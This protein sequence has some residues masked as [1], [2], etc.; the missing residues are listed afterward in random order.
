[1]DEKAEIDWVAIEVEYRAGIRTIQDI[2]DQYKVTK[3][4]I[5]N[6]AK[7]N[8]W[9]RDLSGK[10]K[11]KADELVNKAR[12]NNS[13]NKDKLFTEKV[14]VQT[15]AELQAGAILQESDE[16][17]RLSGIAEAMEVELEG[18]PQ[19]ADGN[20]LDLEKRSRILKQLT[21]VREKIIN[22]R[23]R[24]LGINDNANGTADQAQQVTEIRRVV[25]YPASH[26]DT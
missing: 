25:V 11:A 22:L 7:R 23:R 18:M 20:V 15:A 1:M 9:L 13:V 2:A 12:V 26:D 10:I 3:G 16:I 5:G 6:R 24:N 19:D 8:D 4:A 14:A 21:D 17:K